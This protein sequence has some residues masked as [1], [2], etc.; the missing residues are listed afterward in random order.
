MALSNA[1]RQ[2]RYRQRL[3]ARAAGEALGEQARLAVDR[4]ISALWQF[5]Q[6]P[7]PGG[8]DWAAIDGCATIDAYRAELASAP[9]NLVDT[10]RAF[11][12]DWDGVTA[13]ERAALS[14]VIEAADALSMRGG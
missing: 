7:G 11:L 8:I 14:A 5:R 1:E 4:A 2:R 6:R 3:K 12:P 9:G 10:A 13:E